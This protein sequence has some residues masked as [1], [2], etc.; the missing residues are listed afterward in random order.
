[1]PLE[2]GGHEAARQLRGWRAGKA[3]IES[4]DG[5]EAQIEARILRDHIGKR[6]PGRRVAQPQTMQAVGVCKDEVAAVR[7][8]A[9]DEDQRP[10]VESDRGGD[11]QIRIGRVEDHRCG[12]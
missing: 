9:V 11:A 5:G 6:A 12:R 8:V 3:P 10:I 2:G 1:M 4:P 7:K